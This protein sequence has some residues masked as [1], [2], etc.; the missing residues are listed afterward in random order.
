MARA[1]EIFRENLIE[2]RKLRAEDAELTIALSKSR[3][4]MERRVRERTKEL[5]DCRDHLEDM[6]EERQRESE[7]ARQEAERAN[8]AKSEFLATMSHEL[9]T[10]LT[11]IKGSVGLLDALMSDNLPDQGKE[12]LKMALRNSD[13]MLLLVNEL[14]D[15][16]KILSRSLAIKTSPHDIC[17]LTSKVVRDNQ[18]LASAQSIK[19]EFTKPEGPAFAEVHA[20]R[21][22]QV[23]RN[24]LS[25]AAKFSKPD[26]DVGISVINND[27]TVAVSVTDHG[28]GIP[29]EFRSKIFEQF[30]QIDSSS[31]RLNTGTGLGLSISKALTEGV[32]GTLDFESQLGVGSTFYVRF[33]TVG[34]PSGKV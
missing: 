6:V 14:L 7:L 25:N 19:F 32:G 3:D 18:G 15:Y 31:T 30:T 16:E 10:P 17:E 22:E 12:L 29:D 11:S 28:P 24:L 13:A 20:H 26:S 9:R 8:Q 4:E 5:A 2:I 21:F 23:L 34:D 33:P 1:V 27:Q